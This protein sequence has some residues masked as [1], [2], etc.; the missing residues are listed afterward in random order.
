M[1]L[2]TKQ[3]HGKR[4]QTFSKKKL[5]QTPIN[6]VDVFNGLKTLLT[7]AI[8]K[9]YMVAYSK[10]KSINKKFVISVSLEASTFYDHDTYAK[11]NK[12]L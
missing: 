6:Q 5:L 1:T 4:D 2:S 3:F 7:L 11:T 12:I 9:D 8:I 10:R